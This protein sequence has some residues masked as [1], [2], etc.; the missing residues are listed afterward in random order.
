MDWIPVAEGD[1]HVQPDVQLEGGQRYR[2]TFWLPL[3]PPGWV[4]DLLRDGL[5][6]VGVNVESVSVL[7]TTLELVFLG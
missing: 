4:A 1:E 6:A 5:R 7:G 3:E 2:L